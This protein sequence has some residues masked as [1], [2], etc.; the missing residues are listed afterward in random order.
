MDFEMISRK[1][2]IAKNLSFYFTGKPCSRGHLEKRYVNSSNCVKCNAE[3][4]AK[5]RVKKT[6]DIK[7]ANKSWRENNK[8]YIYNKNKEWK[9]KNP[10]KVKFYGKKYYEKNKERL[11][12]IRKEYREKTKE[13]SYELSKKWIE[14]NKEKYL[15]NRRLW[16]K[17]KN[18]C[19]FY[20]ATCSIRQVTIDAFRRKGIKKSKKTEN[21]LGCS[22]Q[23]AREYIQNKFIDGMTWFN[24]GEWHIDHII[25]LSSAKNIEELTALAHYKN[26][27]PLWRT[28]N[29]KKGSKIN[30]AS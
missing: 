27:Q 24:H 13:K 3:F 18:N 2:A 22:I 8:E 4:H 17:S 23:E 14:E 15:L 10:E 28:D 7:I 11:K 20:I 19:E 9:E 5:R 16:R 21:L 29:L 6:N 26:L 12:P 1:E 25:P 30:A